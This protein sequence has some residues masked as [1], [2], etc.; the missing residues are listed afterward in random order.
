[1]AADHGGDRPVDVVGNRCGDLRSISPNISF[2]LFGGVILFNNLDWFSAR[3]LLYAAISLTLIRM[4]PV[5]IAMIG[6]DLRARTVGFM[7]WFGPRGLASIIFG[8]VVVEEV[9]M[10]GGEVIVGTMVVVVTLSI[11]LHGATAYN[12]ADS[13]ADWVESSTSSP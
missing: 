5:A 1:M 10:E 9:G 11:L 2:A 6:T 7:G 8:A 13:Y 4:I 3:T 12:G